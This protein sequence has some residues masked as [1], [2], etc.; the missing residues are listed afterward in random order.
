MHSGTDERGVEIR[1]HRRRRPASR[2][3]REQVEMALAVRMGGWLEALGPTCLTRD[4][5]DRPPPILLAN[6]RLIDPC[7]TST[8]SATC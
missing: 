8:L 2:L 3:I 6:A 7:A 1:L 5:S 4:I